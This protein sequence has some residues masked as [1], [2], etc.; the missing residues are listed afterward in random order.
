VALHDLPVSAQIAIERHC[1]HHA[2]P[3]R[4]LSWRPGVL[5]DLGSRG[6][7]VVV[8]HEIPEGSWVRFHVPGADFSAHGM[9][10]RAE[11][12]ETP[13]GC[14]WSVALEIANAKSAGP[15]GKATRRGAQKARKA[16]RKEARNAALSSA[17]RAVQDER[18]AAK[19][20]PAS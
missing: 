16:A 13:L 1:L 8:D 18:A 11:Q 15:V 2:V 9:V 10:T 12:L 4:S 20:P 3:D 19:G 7:R 6:A 5:E 17:R 14:R